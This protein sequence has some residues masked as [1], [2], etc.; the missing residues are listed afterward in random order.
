M[1]LDITE[2]ILRKKQEDKK[3]Y[4]YSIKEMYN[5]IERQNLSAFLDYEADSAE[6]EIK[7]ILQYYHLQTA[8]LLETILPEQRFDYILNTANVMSREIQLKSKWW[9]KNAMPLLCIEKK[10]NSYHATI[11]GKCG[12]LYYYDTNLRKKVRITK[13]NAKQFKTEA[14]CF[15]QPLPEKSLTAWELLCY[16]IKSVSFSDYLF[17]I[18]SSLVVTLLGL[19]L[20]LVNNYIFQFVIPSSQKSDIPYVFILLFGV[21][22]SSSMFRLFR[23]F[24]I[25][26]IGDK[27]KNT[28]E[29]GL[30]N[31]ILNLSP[32]FFKQ[33]DSGELTSRAVMLEQICDIIINSI[34]PVLLTILFSFV[35]LI[36]ISSF[37]KELLFPVLLILISMFSFSCLHSFFVV[38]MNYKQNKIKVILSGFVYQLFQAINVLKVNGAELRAF[39]KWAELYGKKMKIFPN[40]IVKFA[41]SIHILITLGG[42][43]LIYNT[44]FQYNLSASV[45]ISFQVAFG[46]LIGTLAHFSEIVTQI[47]Y[48]KPAI[49]MLQPI[50]KEQPEKSKS[51]TRV[52]KLGGQIDINNLCFRYSKDMDLVINNLTL[53][54]QSGEYVAFVGPSGCGKSTLFRLLLGFEKADKGAVYYDG[55]DFNELDQQSVRRRIGTVLQDGKLFAGDIYSNI[56]LCAP[57]LTME[58][59][60]LAAKQ[61]GCEEDIKHMPMGMFTMVSDEGG[62]ISGGQKQRILIART[63]AMNPDIIFFD[64]ATSALD[65]ITQKRV[66]E[67]LS[68]KKITRIVIAHRLSTIKDCDRIIYFDK[69]CIA[70]QG[71]YEELMKKKGKFYELAKWQLM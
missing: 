48:I 16:L 60:W 24:W 67:S 11:P 52:M 2:Q 64:E 55:K 13:K 26:R 51:K 70:E 62:G 39:S 49:Q 18:F 10:D 44:V 28:A 47:A 7:L 23:A 33:Y 34:L 1:I 63:L 20:P 50:L 46:F 9:C 19:I 4:E 71:T 22:L 12:G 38:G 54:I 58:E 8:T 37:S 40:F 14:F 3:Q 59:A 27:I 21:V 6:K 68:Q 61:A 29:A 25:A 42:S 5:I 43:I 41:D 32:Q 66:V 65:N 53:S 17:L 56:A 36:Q 15:Y 31:R 35:Y 69:G 30:W 57:E 45:Y